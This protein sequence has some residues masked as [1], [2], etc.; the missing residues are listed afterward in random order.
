MFRSSLFAIFLLSFLSCSYA[1]KGNQLS[2]K[3]FDKALK[4]EK[5]PQL[6][7][8]RTSDEFEEAHISDAENIDWNGDSFDEEASKLDKTRPV[9]VYCR[10]GK[11]SA[12]AARHMREMGFTKVYELQG[13]I[14]GWEQAGLLHQD[15]EETGNKKK[16]GK[17]TEE[18]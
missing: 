1:Q 13:G 18:E 5:E 11:R 10:S 6:V 12:D 4:A 17:D 3:D 14:L 7:D 16:K 9:Y 8:V 2:P 15:N